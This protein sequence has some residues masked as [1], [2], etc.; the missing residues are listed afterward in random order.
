[1]ALELSPE[2][3]VIFAALVEEKAGITY[4]ADDREL[5]Q[6]KLASRA[7]E[8]GFESLLDY[9]YYLRYDPGSASELQ[10]L[11]DTLVVNESYLF[12]ELEQLRYVVDEILVPAVAA[13]GRPRV[14]S[15]AC[16]AGEEP[17]GLAMML[18][19]RGVLGGVEIV[20]SD[21][22][23][24]ALARARRGELSRRALRDVAEPELA[25]RWVDRD[26]AGGRVRGSI[27]Q[28]IDFRQL[29][30]TDADAVR[31]L[32]SFDVILCRNVLIYFSDETL[33]RVLRILL[34]R[35]RPDGTVWVGVSE[36][37][38]RFEPQVVCEERRGLFFYRRGQD[39]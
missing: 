32:G 10:Q 19:D 8:V 13:G 31:R 28:R 7:V 39:G 14:W 21:I 5:L 15:A 36:S 26:G 37:L 20:A 18:A 1:M 3:F 29:N 38:M 33:R 23:S 24:R 25:A 2:V 30:L 16:A 9:Y 17:F 12:R 35:L 6:A 11:I 22:S 34:E 4:H 27:L